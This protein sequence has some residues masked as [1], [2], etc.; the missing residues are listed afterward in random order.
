MSAHDDYVRYRALR[1]QL[2]DV[3]DGVGHVAEELSLSARATHIGS[4]RDRLENTCFRLMVLGEFKRGKSTLVNAMLGATVL[5][6]RVAPCTGMITVVRYGDPPSARLLPAEEGADPVPV[7]LD[8]IRDHIT[9]SYD[10]VDD[11]DDGK[12]RP[13]ASTARF[14][15]SYPLPLL[16]DGVEL[17]DSPGLNEHA[18]RTA[19][20]LEDL[21]RADAVVLVLSCEQQLGH[22]ERGFIEQQLVP[23]PDGGLSNVFFVWNRFDTIAD[24]PAEVAALDALTESVLAPCLGRDRARVFKVSARDALLG[25]VQEQPD[26]LA[27]SGLPDFEAALARFLTRNRARAKMLGPSQAAAAAITDLLHSVLPER[28]AVLRAPVTQLEARLEELMPRLVQVRQRRE[29]LVRAL[30]A[31]RLALARRLRVKL[32]MF[33]AQVHDGLPEA[34]DRVQVQWAGAAWNRRGVLDALREYLSTW[35]DAEATRFERDHIRPT[36][37]HEAQELDL[38]LEEQLGDLLS[39]LDDMRSELVPRMSADKEGGPDMSATERVLSALGGFVMGGPGGA[40][41][42]ATFGWRNVVGGLP[43]YLG[44]GVALALSGASLPIALSVVTGVGVLRTWLTGKGTAERL[45]DDVLAGFQ[46]AFDR[47]LGT[48]STR[49]EDEVSARYQRLIDAVDAATEAVIVELE[50][51]LA[52]VRRRH[53]DGRQ[54][55]DAGLAELARHRARLDTLAAQ[56]AAVEAGLVG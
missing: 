18:V 53:I 14:E 15:L 27:E 1:R 13:P 30:E 36:L 33:G 47:E 8:R 38:L 41:E 2:V 16:A 20:A 4:V 12:V 22:T 56:L 55:L 52:D 31:R 51:E 25:R 44:V 37:E 49:V 17:V 46:Q 28:E 54:T 10:D 5:P 42:G 40:V 29:A 19:L 7:P 45:R 43:V 26:R 6:T 39:E 32:G 21:P 11:M 9:I 23:G 24:D 35:L 34:I 3:L 48:M 50:E